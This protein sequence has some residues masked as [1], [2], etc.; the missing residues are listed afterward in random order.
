VWQFVSV[1]AG[2]GQN[3]PVCALLCQNVP[4]CALLVFLVGC[5]IFSRKIGNL[6][7]ELRAVVDRKTFDAENREA[8]QLSAT[9]RKTLQLSVKRYF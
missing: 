5:S 3:V 1:C 6:N 8:L 9:F 2:L 4:V 7:F